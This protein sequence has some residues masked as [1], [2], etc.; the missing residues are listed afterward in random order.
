[1]PLAYLFSI[2]ALAI[3]VAVFAL[4]NADRVTISF[5]AWKIEGAPLAAVILVSGAVGALL[6]S[7]VGSLQRWKLRSQIRQLESRLKASEPPNPMA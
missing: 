5:L 4:Q 3:A 2:A 6:V 1:M 7:L